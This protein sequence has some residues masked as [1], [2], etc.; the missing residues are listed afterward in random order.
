MYKTEE[1]RN[2]GEYG[3]N[4]WEKR[5]KEAKGNTIRP[6]EKVVALNFMQYKNDDIVDRDP[7]ETWQGMLLAVTDHLLNDGQ[8]PNKF[9]NSRD[10]PLFI[11]QNG[12][13]VLLVMFPER[14][15]SRWY[16]YA[17]SKALRNHRSPAF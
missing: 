4:G 10:V 1:K 15:K 13:K 14:P 9:L 3:Q 7:L 12:G 11:S 17:Q 8:F 2:K 16:P 5:Q 6:G